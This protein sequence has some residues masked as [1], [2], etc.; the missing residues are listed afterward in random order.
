MKQDTND[1]RVRKTKRAIREAFAEL[2]IQKDIQKI[3]IR[4]LTAKA[5]IHRA[6]FYTHYKDIYDLYEQIEQS[7]IDELEHIIYTDS[8]HTY[9]DV[10]IDLIDFIYDNQKIMRMFFNKHTKYSFYNH[11]CHYLETKYLTLLQNDLK[12]QSLPSEYSYYIRYHIHGFL[13]VLTYWAEESFVSPK[14]KIVK[15]ALELDIHF[16]KLLS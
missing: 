11:F 10:I 15:I 4:E 14:E 13:A 3:S 2:L 12:R 8:H 7:V 5:D 16:D 6:T 9:D 1:R